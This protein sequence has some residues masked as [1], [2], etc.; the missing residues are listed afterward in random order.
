[1][2]SAEVF[3]Y[4]RF[5]NSQRALSYQRIKYFKKRKLHIIF[6]PFIILLKLKLSEDSESG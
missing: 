3:K 1:M 2:T 6:G 5:K 4:S